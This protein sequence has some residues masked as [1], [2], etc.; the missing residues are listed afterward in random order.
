M[1]DSVI[2]NGTVIDGSGGERKIADVAIKAGRIAAIGSINPDDAEKTIDAD[3]LIVAPGFVDLHTHYDAQVFWDPLMSPSPFHGVTTV[4]GGLCGFTLQ[5]LN[6]DAAGYLVPMLSQVEDIPLPSLEAGVPCDWN[7][8]AGFRKGIEGR[9]AI[10]CGFSTGHSAL[11]R[12]AMGERAMS[13]KASPEDIVQMRRLLAEALDQGALGFSTSNST[14]HSDHNGMPVPSRYADREE[15]VALAA[16]CGA[17]EGAAVEIQPGLLFDDATADLLAEMS[18]ASGRTVNWNAMFTSTLDANERATIERQLAMSDHARSRGGDVVGLTVPITAVPHFDLWR[19]GVFDIV[20][21][22]DRLIRLAPAD[23]IPALRDASFRDMLR[24]AA[25]S[26]EAQAIQVV[27]QLTDPAFIIVEAGHSDIV[28]NLAGR[29]IASI[30]GE[31]G[32]DPFDTLLDVALDDGLHTLFTFAD[33]GEDEATYRFRR[34]LWRDDRLC[35]GGSDAGAHVETIDTFSYF[36]RMIEQAVRRF[37]VISLEECIHHLTAAPASLSGLRDRGM[38]K[39]GWHADLVLF[40]ETSIA[41]RAIH[42]RSD[43][44][45]GASRLYAEA[46]GIERVIVAGVPVIEQGR[47]TGARPGQFLTRGKDTYSVGVKG[48]RAAA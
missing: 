45:T 32:T 23:R 2:R 44:P 35:V 33:V 37:G 31:R 3:G 20:P 1:Y 25:L 17:Y 27:R 24:A 26:P 10:N 40:D 21:G 4:L 11:R 38:I 48:Q 15:F 6:A 30:A 29:S 42:T 36:T 39:S 19:G 13:E 18:I 7:D 46:D 16:C 12:V 34:D 9:T 28:R 5:P 8:F 14:T 47:D 43:F 41:R 22:W